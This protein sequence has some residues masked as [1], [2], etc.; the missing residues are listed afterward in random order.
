MKKLELTLVAAITNA[1]LTSSAFASSSPG[2]YETV[3]RPNSPAATGGGSLGYNISQEN[4]D[5]GN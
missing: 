1:M 2:N 3:L 4:V 5:R